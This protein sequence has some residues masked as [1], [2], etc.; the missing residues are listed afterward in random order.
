MKNDGIRLGDYGLGYDIYLMKK[1]DKTTFNYLAPEI[2][3]KEKKLYCFSSD[4]W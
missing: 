4:V 1:E 3:D 2:L